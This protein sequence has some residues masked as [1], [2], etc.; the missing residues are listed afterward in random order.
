METEGRGIAG[1]PSALHLVLLEEVTKGLFGYRVWPLF[2]PCSQNLYLHDQ[3]G[4]DAEIELF[5]WRDR[6]I[7]TV[8][9]CAVHW[10]SIE[11]LLSA[12][13]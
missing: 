1:Y 5:L 10:M 8:S 13:I 12:V 9:Y 3:L 7:H 11:S 4:I 6:L 2:P